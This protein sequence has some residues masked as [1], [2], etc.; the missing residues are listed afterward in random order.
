MKGEV[1]EAYLDFIR[2]MKCAVCDGR[3][4][5]HHLEAVGMGSKRGKN[6]KGSDLTA[7]PLCIEHHS[8]L[9][10][11]GIP[12]FEYDYRHIK[13]RIWRIAFKC[14]LMYAIKIREEADEVAA[15]EMEEARN[16][17]KLMAECLEVG[18]Y[19]TLKKRADRWLKGVENVDAV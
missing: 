13:V 19:S 10:T 4:D 2:S 6:Q 18:M 5:P 9:E 15:K 17:I 16:L 8:E 11:S 3:A 14:F 12:K 1:N 7:I